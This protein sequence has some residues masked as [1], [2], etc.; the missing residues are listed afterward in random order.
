MPPCEYGQG[1]VKAR[2]RGKHI[3]LAGLF[4]SPNFGGKEWR[5][6]P[7]NEFLAANPA[8]AQYLIGA[9]VAIVAFFVKRSFDNLTS[10][11][12]SLEKAINVGK[13]D[14]GEL[15]DRMTEQETRCEM[16]RRQCPSNRIVYPSMKGNMVQGIESP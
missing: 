15:K 1:I 13:V 11:I 4:F 5:K 3:L 2:L 9:L 6:H 8:L 14:I 10:A 7:V 16:Q 12:Q